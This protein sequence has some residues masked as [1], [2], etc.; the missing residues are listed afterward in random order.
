MK[1][2]MLRGTNTSIGNCRA[3]VVYELVDNEAAKLVRLNRAEEVVEI[4]QEMVDRSIG[5]E[6]SDEK[7][8]KRGRPRKIKDVTE[9]SQ[10]ADDAS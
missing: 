9:E 2:L 1:I 8:I 4:T 7:P 10:E 6:V 3:G 5:L